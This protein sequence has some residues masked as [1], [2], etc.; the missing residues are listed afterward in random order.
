MADHT[1]LS[2]FLSLIL[3]HKPEVIN[4]QL[5]KNGWADTQELLKKMNMQGKKIDFDLLKEVVAT[6]N[7]KR[8]LF[9]DDLTKIKAN[10]GH[11]IEI[12]LG[13]E[14]II[15]PEFL[16][17]GTATKN[18]D[19]ILVSG[20]NKGSRHHVHLSLDEGTAINVGQRHGKPLVLKIRALE[21]HEKGIAFYKTEN[22]VWLTDFVAVEFIER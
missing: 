9:N 2:K 1:Q 10:Q 14:A 16:Y 19:S 20:I 11:S 18:L 21:M 6:N 5:D 7:K 4:V 3:R 15:P 22:N 17:H 12:E 8:F 13:L